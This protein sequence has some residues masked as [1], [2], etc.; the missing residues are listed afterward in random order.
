MTSRVRSTSSA[1]LPATQDSAI[2]LKALRKLMAG[3]AVA[4]PVPD[5][6]SPVWAWLGD[7]VTTRK[8]GD[9]PKVAVMTPA[10]SPH[11]WL[12]VIVDDQ[13]FL[14]DTISMAVRRHNP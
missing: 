2:G 8:R 6:K 14:T 3:N 11:G 5:T 9:A 7:S 1:P 12:L 10:G 4:L 13:P